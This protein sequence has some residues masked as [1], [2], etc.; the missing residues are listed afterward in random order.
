MTEWL[1]M[2]IENKGTEGAYLCRRKGY[3]RLAL[4][5]LVCFFALVVARVGRACIKRKSYTHETSE[6][7]GSYANDFRSNCRQWWSGSLS[8]RGDC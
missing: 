8:V 6:R 5:A 2:C 3:T 1:L 4:E 7:G